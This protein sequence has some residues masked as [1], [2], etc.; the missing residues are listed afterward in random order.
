MDLYWFHEYV[1]ENI[2]GSEERWV[3]AIIWR[4]NLILDR[5]NINIEM[6]AAKGQL[7][8]L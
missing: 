2:M 6:A 4:K 3:V 8:R 7:H 5:M 1:P